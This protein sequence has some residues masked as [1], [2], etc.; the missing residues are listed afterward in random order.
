MLFAPIPGVAAA[1]PAFGLVASAVR[2]APDSVPRWEQGVAW[3]QERCG[4]TYRLVAWCQEPAAEFEPPR[5][6][7]AYYRPVELNT[8]DECSTLGGPVDLDRVRR[9]AEA[10][11]PFAVARELWSGTLAADT[12]FTVPGGDTTRNA[13][14]A[15][16]DATVVG[17]GEASVRVGI[18]RLEQAAMEASHG[19]AVMLHV[20]VVVL[21]QLDGYVQR[22]GNQL[23]TLAGN[24]LVADG[25][26]PGT[27]PNAEPVG[28]TAWAYA[29]APVAV[30]MSPLAPI[31]D[32]HTVIDRAS[33][34]R[35]TWTSRV[36]AAVF[37]PCLHL[38]TELTI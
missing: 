13:Y 32:D 19:Q 35:T 31:T 15:S 4:T 10:K 26:Y 7:A 37:D 27:G 21:P 20:P 1:P 14:L 2:P 24:T 30:L 6:G 22:V 28:T 5:P 29:T 9:V 33:N 3:V 36:F 17:A 23:L 18:G 11:A 38:A 34:T 8:A 12:P 25:G 16:P